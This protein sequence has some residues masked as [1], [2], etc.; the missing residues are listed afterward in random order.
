MQCTAARSLCKVAALTTPIDMACPLCGERCTCSFARATRVDTS[1]PSSLTYEY[2]DEYRDIKPAAATMN[3][4]ETMVPH[5]EDPDDRMF[6]EIVAAPPE[7][8][9]LESARTDEPEEAG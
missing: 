3:Y 8:L 4:S 6:S 7:D 5:Q 1:A 9:T 2:D